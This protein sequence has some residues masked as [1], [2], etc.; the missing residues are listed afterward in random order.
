[1][2]SESAQL[3]KLEDY[4]ETPYVI[5]DVSLVFKLHAEATEVVFY[6]YA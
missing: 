3:I 5:K 4:A 2:R 6:A 1:M